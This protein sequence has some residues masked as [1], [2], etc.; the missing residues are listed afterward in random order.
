[1]DFTPFNVVDT[2]IF[3][4]ANSHAGGQLATEY[5]LKSRESVGT[6]HNVQY[7]IGSSYVHSANDFNVT[8]SGTTLKISS[9]RAVVNG[10]FIE[11]LTDFTI[12]LTEVISTIK[13]DFSGYRPSAG[14]SVGLRANYATD[15]TLSG[16]M[17][18]E[19]TEGV[20]QGI[21]VVL[22]P[23]FNA[24]AYGNNRS[25][26]TFNTPSDVPTDSTLVTAHLLLA[27]FTFINGSIRNLEAN[28]NVLAIFSAD[29]ISDIDSSLV[30]DY[31]RKDNLQPNKLYTFSGKSKNWCNSVDSLMVWDVGALNNEP[32]TTVPTVTEARFTADGNNVYLEVPHKQVDGLEDEDHNRLYYQPKRYTIPKANFDIGTPGIVDAEYSATLKKLSNRFNELYTL[33]NGTYL[34]YIPQLVGRTYDPNNAETTLP[35]IDTLNW[36][37]GDYIIVGQDNSVE[38]ATTEDG[39]VKYPSTM[40]LIVGAVTELEGDNPPTTQPSSG[41]NLGTVTVTVDEDDHPETDEEAKSKFLGGVNQYGSEGDYFTY[42]VVGGSSYYYVVTSINKQ[43]SDPIYLTGQL[44]LATETTIG[45]FLNVPSTQTDAGYVYRDEYGYLRLL[46]YELLRS[47]TLAYQLGANYTIPSGVDSESIQTYLDEYINERVAFPNAQQLAY[48]TATGSPIDVIEVTMYL[49]KADDTTVINIYDLDSRFSTCT[50]FHILGEADSKTTVNF[51][52]CQRIRID[53]NISGSP[54]INLQ[55]TELYYDAV[56]LNYIMNCPRSASTYQTMGTDYTGIKDLKLWY[57]QYSDDDPEIYV[58]GMTVISPDIAADVASADY[59][60][61]NTTNDYHYVYALKSVTFDDTCKMIGCEMLIKNDTT[62]TAVQA[63]TQILSGEYSLPQSTRLIYPEASIR[64]NLKIDGCFVTA[65]NPAGES[66]YITMRTTFTAVSGVAH[67]EVVNSESAPN[68]WE[69][70]YVNYYRVQTVDG[71]DIYT[72]LITDSSAPTWA[73]N[74]YYRKVDAT[75]NIAILIEIQDSAPSNLNAVSGT[76]PEIPGW[77]TSSYHTFIGGVSQ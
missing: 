3:P 53:Q 36:N 17:L 60:S 41:V 47:G 16:S 44:S 9:G 5:N 76:M 57:K 62:A 13:S 22:L 51:V 58:D 19:D 30:G 28:P 61:S 40:Y 23:T 1:M 43:Y 54:I 29:R 15:T 32:T 67:Y 49:P 64:D 66:K 31:V 26:K 71:V 18:A 70:V 2:N 75:G 55:N 4:V 34:K 42:K 38:G 63:G 11:S 65:Y 6:D 52:N 56:T 37:I 39:T 21:S 73:T 12:D 33:G 77:S 68:N 50:Y 35:L 10:H 46:D 14:L 25:I 27:T 74:T 69:T 7:T 20:Y 72:S 8:C 24:S 59:W 45:G 48:A